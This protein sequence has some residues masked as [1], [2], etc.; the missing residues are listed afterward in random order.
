MKNVRV[1][2]KI[3]VCAWDIGDSFQG[4]QS[5]GGEDRGKT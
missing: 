4:V 5:N 2:R 3:E 1:V